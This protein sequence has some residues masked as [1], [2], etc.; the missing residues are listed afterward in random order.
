MRKNMQNILS[1]FA[2]IG[3]IFP[4]LS[5]GIPILGFLIKP[6]VHHAWIVV[7]LGVIAWQ[8]FNAAQLVPQCS[9]VLGAIDALG[10][11]TAPRAPGEWNALDH[12]KSLIL[13]CIA[14]TLLVAGARAF[15]TIVRIVI[16]IKN[17]L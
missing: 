13:P 5:I 9:N 11:A 14:N 8:L 12:F 2:T 15:S 10:N 3:N 7:F 1:T 4:L 16:A 6:V 17:A